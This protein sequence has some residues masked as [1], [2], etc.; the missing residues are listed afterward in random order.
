M[1]RTIFERGTWQKLRKDGAE[2]LIK[3]WLDKFPY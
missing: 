1:G 2:Q 3:H